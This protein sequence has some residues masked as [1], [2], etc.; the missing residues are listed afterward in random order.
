MEEFGRT[1]AKVVPARARRAMG[2]ELMV[3][4]WSEWWVFRTVRAAG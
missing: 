3:E 1:S 4:M 2:M